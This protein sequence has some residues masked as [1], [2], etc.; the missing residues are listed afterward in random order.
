MHRPHHLLLPIFFSLGCLSA[1]PTNLFDDDGTL[2]T[3]SINIFNSP[4]DDTLTS[5][6]N[7]AYESSSFISPDDHSDL[8]IFHD[9]AENDRDSDSD[10]DSDFNTPSTSPPVLL[11]L[12]PEY[13][14]SEFH[15]DPPGAESG[16]ECEY[17]RLAACCFDKN[18]RDCTWYSS[19]RE[20][21]ENVDNVVCCEQ[22][23]AEGQ[24]R[25]CQDIESWPGVLPDQLLDILRLTVPLPEGLPG[26]WIPGGIWGGN[27]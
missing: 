16:P 8:S 4:A 19:W 14:S 21:C 2:M 12:D 10:P 18:W 11:S 7:K 13:P 9:F 5:A 27:E 1:D 24:G 23:T 3:N 17:P 22:V 26:G 20:W 6:S 25:N 15:D